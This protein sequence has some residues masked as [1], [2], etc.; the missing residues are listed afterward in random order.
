MKVKKLIKNIARDEHIKIYDSSLS[1][2]YSGIVRD[3]YIGKQFLDNKVKEVWC[4]ECSL[5]IEY[6]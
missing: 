6:E 3:I 1:I 5:C 2:Q 4:D